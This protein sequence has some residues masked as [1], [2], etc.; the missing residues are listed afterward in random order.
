MIM[1]IDKMPKTRSHSLC[2][3]RRP[4]DVYSFAAAGFLQMKFNCIAEAGFTTISTN[5][6]SFKILMKF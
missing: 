3:D 5:P 2:S 4:G 1:G 6:A